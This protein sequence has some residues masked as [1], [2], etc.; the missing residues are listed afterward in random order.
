MRFRASEQNLVLSA[1]IAPDLPSVFKGD[2][3]K[4]SQV[5]LNLIGN[6]LK[7]TR[8]G[9]VRLKVAGSW[10]S[11]TARYLLRFEVADS[12]SGIAPEDQA[13]LFDAFYQ[14]SGSRAASQEGTGLGLAICKRLVT[15]MNGEIGVVSS[16][17]RGSRFWFTLPLQ[18][19]DP[20]AVV[21]QGMTLPLGDQSLGKREVLLVE[22]NEVNAT[23]AR[24]FLEKMGHQVTAVTSGEAAVEAVR[25][26]SYDLALMDISLPGI[27]GVEATRRIRDE[28]GPAGRDLPIVAMSAH[29]FQDEIAAHLDAGMDA[30]LGKPVAPERLAEVLSEVLRRSPPAIARVTNEENSQ[31]PILLDPRTLNDDVLILGTEKTRRMIEAFCEA[32]PDQLAALSAAFESEDWSRLAY[33]A[34]SLKGGAGSL[35]LLAL[36]TSSGRLEQAA[37]SKDAEAL[38]ESFTDYPA[39]YE[40]SREAVQRVWQALG[41]TQDGHVEAKVSPAKM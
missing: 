38:S 26:G 7:F 6:G 3:G 21:T 2:S 41:E 40:R 27:D 8:E 24:A 12:G 30:F 11:E 28:C 18:E 20:E 4:V 15:A 25:D 23:V 37:L 33:L 35:G 19:G 14:V 10:N 34:H 16:L 31:G 36:E 17:G 5:L 32:A 39:L 1:E 9:G 13:A 29:V 22:D